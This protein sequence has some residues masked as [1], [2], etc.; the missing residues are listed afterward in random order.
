MKTPQTSLVSVIGLA[1]TLMAGTAQAAAPGY[2]PLQGTLTD[3][4]GAPIATTVTAAFGLYASETDA[5]PLWSETRQISPTSDGQFVA[6]LGQ[7]T[8]LDPALFRDHN[9]LW[10]Q[11]AVGSDAPMGRVL[12][13]SAPYSDYAEHCGHV[14]ATGLPPGA[15]VG[16]KTC[17]DGQKVTGVDALGGLVCA[18]DV[19]YR[20]V[21]ELT[22]ALQGQY[23]AATW[24]PTWSD[25]S[26]TPSFARVATTGSYS[27]LMG[28]VPAAALPA[29]VVMGA[30]ACNAGDKAV[31]VDAAGALLCGADLGYKSSDELVTA[32]TGQYRA[33][34][35]VPGWAD[36]AN[37]PS[38]AAVS[39][40]GSYTDLVN[41]PD[42]NQVNGNIGIGMSSPVSKL[43]VLGVSG[44][45]SMWVQLY[46]DISRYGQGLHLQWNRGNGDG[47]AY[48]LNQRGLGFGGFVFGEVDGNTVTPV[49]RIQSNITMTN[50]SP[51]ILAGHSSNTIDSGVRGATIAGGGAQSGSITSH[52][53]NRARADFSTIGGGIGNQ[54]DAISGAIAGGDGNRVTQ[55]YGAVL[56]GQGNVAAGAWSAVLGGQ[57]NAALGKYSIAAGYGSEAL[58]NGSF[59]AGY[60]AMAVAD[61]CFVWGDYSPTDPDALGTIDC[62]T[63]NQFL[64]RASGGVRF[65]TDKNL[66]TGVTLGAGGGSWTSVSDRNQKE[67]IVPVDSRDVLA[68]VAAMPVSTWR[69]KSEVSRA[70]HMGPMA[71]DFH[72]AFA[73][74]DSDKSITTIDAD[75]VA[76]AAIQGLNQKLTGLEAEN[77]ALRSDV[78]KLNAQMARILVAQGASGHS[79][80][81]G[82][83]AFGLCA[84]GIGGVVVSRRSRKEEQG[85]GTQP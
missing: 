18:P 15:L 19:G 13:G 2:L 14:L 69:Y 20:S 83:L 4:S 82:F 54:V 77:A 49:L 9:S 43:D 68:R 32:L 71:Q 10:L 57:G 3:P 40:T 11:T 7:V 45:T 24:T 8:P 63:P 79:Q 36:I 35:W 74:G 6:Y 47:A 78:A 37:R 34:S 84:A 46:D 73:L 27:D 16:A 29:G 50:G 72:A 39:T 33:A 60:G 52:S 1:F 22:G 61:G 65:F 48:I 42:L 81:Y 28:T 85:K 41:R 64:A 44:A 5:T 25:I 67:E 62:Q 53:N 31:G 38:F 75:G 58:G 17:A 26:G 80:S 66:F 12:I 30:K 59:T 55:P 23:R 51:N 70:R 76:L 21:G 56:G